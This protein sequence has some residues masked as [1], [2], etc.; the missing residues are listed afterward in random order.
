M[1]WDDAPPTQEDL[2]PQ[3]GGW[4]ATPPTAEE[5][6]GP[7]WSDLPKNIGPD[8]EDLAKGALGTGMR[9]G[10]G[11]YDL[12]SD[13]VQSG[14]ATLSGGNP[15][16]TPIAQ[17]VKTVGG[18]I[19]N[20]VMG[21]RKSIGD[22]A[23][24]DAWVN[25]PV[26]N[27][28]NAGSIL[29]GGLEG[30]LGAEAGT[31]AAGRLGEVLEKSGAREATG[32]A[33]ITDKT[34]GKMTPRGGN[35]AVTRA[36]LGKR[37]IDD[38]VIGGL[39]ET[40]EKIRENQLGQ[41]DKYGNQVKEALSQIRNSGVPP[42]VSADKALSPILNEW[43][44]LAD[45]SQPEGRAMARRLAA[46]YTKLEDI[47][48]KKGGVLGFDDI[49]NEMES[50]GQTL[51]K[52]PKTSPSY[53]HLSDLYKT[54]AQS[55]DAIV[56]DVSKRSGNLD[57]AK[58]LKDANAGF[59]TYSQIGRDVGKIAAKEGVEKGSN[60]GFYGSLWAMA[61]GEFDKAAEFFVGGRLLG[62]AL[63]EIAPSMAKHTV[64]AGRIMQKYG[65]A[66]EGAAKKGAKNLAVTSSIIA[67]KDPE[68]ANALASLGGSLEQ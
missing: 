29:E 52:T 49:H 10:K 25:H 21:I 2:Q 44:K 56:D 23:S 5:M 60:I 58:Q 18:G 6:R 35:E 39:G 55:K 32:V 7:Q 11:I 1:G 12:P 46:S 57:L 34:I 36:D 28:V 68:Y 30:G 50:V 42:E 62:P 9:I 24:K 20:A 22:L 3:S 31:G 17:D 59:H 51:G 14:A 40:P 65:P 63:K 33:G 64:Q 45:D 48:N 27:A 13:L 38:K 4:D 15:L 66:L 37:L 16:E 53:G 26:Q 54:L 8:A 61:H 47:A 67:N 19:G 43:S 41:K